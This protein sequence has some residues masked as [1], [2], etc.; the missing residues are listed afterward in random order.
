MTTYSIHPLGAGHR[1]HRAHFA[2]K[3]D[4][5]GSASLNVKPHLSTFLSM[6]EILMELLTEP[7]GVRAWRADQFEGS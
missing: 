2:Q 1:G 7:L 4:F 6:L 3:V 5:S